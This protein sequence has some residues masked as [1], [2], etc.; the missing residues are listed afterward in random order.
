MDQSNKEKNLVAKTPSSNRKTHK[1]KQLQN[2]KHI[3]VVYP[4]ATTNSLFFNSNFYD[5][6]VLKVCVRVCVCVCVCIKSG[7]IKSHREAK[8]LV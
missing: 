4:N 5:S 8:L 3:M 7:G 2:G 1:S 6:F